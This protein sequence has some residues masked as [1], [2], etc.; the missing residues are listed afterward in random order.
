[1]SPG[2][3]R[4]RSAYSCA[5]HPWAASGRR[6]RNLPVGRRPRSARR[7][8]ANDA[9]RDKRD[10]GRER[11]Q[12]S[13]L[14]PSKA[15]LGQPESV[16]AD[17][18]RRHQHYHQPTLRGRSPGSAPAFR[19]DD[20]VPPE[21]DAGPSVVCAPCESPIGSESAPQAG[22]GAVGSIA[23][24]GN[25]RGRSTDRRSRKPVG[26]SPSAASTQL[27]LGIGV[28]RYP[29]WTPVVVWVGGHFGGQPRDAEFLASSTAELIP[30]RLG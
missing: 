29:P 22:S 7:P 20:G 18:W 14:H 4:T 6:H 28:Q 2:T 16:V 9:D 30:G 23:G 1:M 24:R 11:G 13:D 5:G 8:S 17:L 27:R 10:E 3:A 12:E 26:W 15:P 21:R 19:G 25:R